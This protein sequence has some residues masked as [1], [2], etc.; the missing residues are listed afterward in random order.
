MRIELTIREIVAGGLKAARYVVGLNGHFFHVA[1]IRRDLLTPRLLLLSA[2]LGIRRLDGYPA[3]RFFLC[4]AS[5][6]TNA[7]NH[8]HR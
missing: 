8:P 4:L 1:L 6:V 2:R 5:P 7:P 3:S